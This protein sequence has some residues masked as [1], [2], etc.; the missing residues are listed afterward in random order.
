[1]DD[2]VRVLG[3][4]ADGGVGDG[5]GRAPYEQGYVEFLPVHFAG[6]GDHLVE[7][8][9]NE[10]AES[11]DIGVVFAGG[12]EDVLEGGHDA[13]VHDLVVVASEHDSD[14]VLADVVDVALD[15]GDDD[16]AVGAGGVGVALLVLD[17]GDELG[18]GLL[19]DAGAL[20]GPGAGTCGP[21]RR[22][23]RR[24]SCRP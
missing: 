16:L 8:R 6:D 12:V 22:G 13:E 14:D 9:G 5:S 11:D 24:H 2:A 17:E 1:M 18:D 10:A 23:R 20:D 4:D 19:H 21:I 15:G 7:G 3:L